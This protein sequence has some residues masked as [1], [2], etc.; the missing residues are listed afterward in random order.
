MR[1]LGGW[2]A[3]DP[4]AS[5]RSLVSPPLLPT[6]LKHL[7]MPSPSQSLLSPAVALLL[8]V[9][10]AGCS[11]ASSSDENPSGAGGGGADT[12]SGGAGNGGASSG[13][14]GTGGVGTG[15]QTG[16]GGLLSDAT[17][18]E[19]SGG[20][21]TG[22][23]GGG[24]GSGGDTGEA[25]GGSGTGG[26]SGTFTLTSSALPDMGEFPDINTCAGDAGNMG[27]GEAIPLEWS[28]FPSETMS[29]ALTMIDVT[30]VD[31][32]DN[33]LGCHSAFWNVPVTTTSLPAADW[34]SALDG[35]MSIR[36]GYLGPCPNFGGG[37]KEDT[38]VFTL[39]A[40]GEA[41]LTDPALNEQAFGNITSCNALRDALD[42]AALASVTLT[43]TSSA[44]GGN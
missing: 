17:G 13:G 30:L 2:D 31:G 15:G 6:A 3:V 22:G 33:Y 9:G 34:S 20:T 7:P 32:D 25:A 40:L 18:G 42:T 24:F 19:G 23:T 27:F 44:V 16:V 37:T 21:P 14:A 26:T 1:A 41:T 12:S 11:D 8:A 35:A 38:Y 29:F 28:G 36:D 39:Y 43:G 5:R 4:L 10:L